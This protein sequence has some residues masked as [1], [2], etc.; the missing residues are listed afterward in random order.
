[1]SE[2]VRIRGIG[3][4]IP[5]TD[6]RLNP[7]FTYGGAPRGILR[8]FGIG[9]D[10][11]QSFRGSPPS[12]LL[13]RS[14]MDTNGRN[15]VEAMNEALK[16]VAA[17]KA[18]ECRRFYTLL[19]EIFWKS[20][21]RFLRF[22]RKATPDDAQD[23]VANLLFS[24]YEQALAGKL[25]EPPRRWQAYLRRAALRRYEMDIRTARRATPR[26]REV[27]LALALS[28]G[29]RPDLQAAD[30]DEIRRMFERTLP[31]LTLMER[32]VIAM[33]GQRWSYAEIANALSIAEI[34][35]G[36]LATRARAK[37]KAER[38]RLKAA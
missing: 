1:M 23:S 26:A 35:V 9:A 29:P 12:L 37:L 17:G 24:L 14:R 32:R 5:T 38:F 11:T 33:R 7:I 10:S 15:P 13:E 36:A 28:D 8:M 22:R 4:G 16:G 34:S 31:K 3:H 20:L 19:F 2:E 18:T 30:R 27:D 25:L 6:G 21:I